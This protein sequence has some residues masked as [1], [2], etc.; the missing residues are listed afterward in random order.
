[1]IMFEIVTGVVIGNLITLV[2]L[3]KAMHDIEQLKATP[4]LESTPPESPYIRCKGML[5]WWRANYPNRG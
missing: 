5:A 2:I 4:E 3:V 1:M